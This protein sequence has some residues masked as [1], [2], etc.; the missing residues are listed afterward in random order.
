MRRWVGRNRTERWV[1]RVS[2]VRAL[3]LNRNR[4]VWIRITRSKKFSC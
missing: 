1:R 3:V 4:T 2:L